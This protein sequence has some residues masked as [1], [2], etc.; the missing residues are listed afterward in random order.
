MPSPGYQLLTL[1]PRRG[2]LVVTFPDSTLFGDTAGLA[3]DFS[4]LTEEDA[5]IIWFDMREVKF[6]DSY[7]IGLLV[8]L[9]TEKNCWLCLKQRPAML[10][11]LIFPCR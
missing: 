7:V 3:Q 11:V 1:T 9:Q 5:A 4:K 10:C 2:G 8:R 6:V